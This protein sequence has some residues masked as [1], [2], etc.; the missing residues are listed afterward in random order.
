[1][2]FV[3]DASVT[4]SWAFAEAHPDANA[5]FDLLDR[6]SAV[7][8]TLWWFEVRNLLLM[9]ERRTQRNPVDTESFL[10][11]LAKLPISVDH[12]PDEK[13]LLRFA[14][15]HRLTVY[16]AAY[17]ELAHRTRSP[18]ATLDGDLIRAAR[19]EGINLVA[20]KGRARR[21]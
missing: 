9:N 6:D 3:V 5:A 13:E 1:M 19:A 18:L 21:P 11:I 17:L 14:R 8:P 20:A 12:A 10:G 7:A 2:S 16:D 15:T 4:A